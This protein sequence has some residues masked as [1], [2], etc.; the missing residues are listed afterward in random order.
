MAQDPFEFWWEVRESGY[1]WAMYE[2]EV[3]TVEG[4]VR[5]EPGELILAT[6]QKIGRSNSNILRYNPLDKKYS[7]LFRQFSETDGDPKA[8]LEF[9]NQYG[10]LLPFVRRIRLTEG[11]KGKVYSW[12]NGEN[13]SFWQSQADAMNKVVRVWDM[14]VDK[15]EGAIEAHLLFDESRG[16]FYDSRGRLGGPDRDEALNDKA[17]EIIGFQALAP[18]IAEYLRPDDRLQRAL[19][20]IQATLNKWLT[21]RISPE[22][23]FNADATRVGVFHVPDSL[24]AAMWLQTAE[25]V[26]EGREYRKCRQCNRRF[27]IH[28]ETHRKNTYYCSDKCK[29]REY[30]MRA[31]ARKL[32]EDGCSIDEIA[33]RLEVNVEAVERWLA[34]DSARPK[35]PK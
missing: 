16:L 17:T 29:Q 15:D 7:G 22:V 13:L 10:S 8:M 35:R 26:Q 12:S 6:K 5:K 28:P 23:R 20:Y 30:R 34:R 32:G 2:E 4:G 3:I 1:R 14:V 21:A 11:A 9:A 25:A 33:A 24:I 19:Y 18:D 31:Q 27:E